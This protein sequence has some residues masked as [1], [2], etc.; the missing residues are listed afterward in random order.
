[1]SAR[2]FAVAAML[3]ALAGAATAANAPDW[4]EEFRIAMAAH[5]AHDVTGYR[6]HL[7]VVQA[8]LGPTAG[9]TY[10][11][12]RAEAMAGRREEAL[13]RLNDYAA[14]G[15]TRNIAADSDF[16]ALFAD[17]AFNLLA[18]R[19]RGNGQMCGEGSSTIA[20]VLVGGV[21]EDVAPV[22]TGWIVTDVYGGGLF[23]VDAG[24]HAK[25]IAPIQGG[26]GAF[27]IRHDEKRQRIWVTLSATPTTAGYAS[28][29]SGRTALVMLDAA[30]G[31]V[32]H[33]YEPPRD[34]A[35]HFGDMTLAPD[36]TVFVSDGMGGTVFRLRLGADALE[37]LLPDGALD[38]PQTPTLAADGR[39]LYVPEYSRGI[40]LVDP[41][42]HSFTRI[43]GG[44]RLF[45]SGIDGLYRDGSTLIAV[46]N[47]A[48]PERIAR[49]T[50]DP[51]GTRVTGW[52]CLVQATPGLGEPT[53]GYINGRDFIYIANSGWDRVGDDQKL[54]PDPNA[55]PAELRR[56]ALDR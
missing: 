30:S 39:R 26:W 5:G 49:F 25:P 55:R 46:Q 37:R 40:A 27:A 41:L 12:A 18:R 2:A 16:V 32:L 4:R 10:Q 28:A 54:Q 1:V 14:A 23:S 22:G 53:H 51:S 13:A 43:Q 48:H 24:G 21:C 9:L 44:A 20:P 35:R 56:I 52:S 8:I 36:G 29:D 47:G 7:D 42:T 11:F 50:L 45:L 34:R 31:K 19:I 3:L 38:S 17:S 6:S 33:R 15:L